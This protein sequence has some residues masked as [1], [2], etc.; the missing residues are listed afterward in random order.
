[1]KIDRKKTRGSAMILKLRHYNRI[2]KITHEIA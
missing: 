1:M 2:M